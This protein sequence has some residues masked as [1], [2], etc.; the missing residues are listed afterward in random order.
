MM[1]EAWGK[2][3]GRP[4]IVMATRGPGATNA[5]AGLHVARQDST[6]MI[7]LLGQVGRKMRGREA[8]QE[9]DAKLFFGE[10]AKS[11]EEIASA[12]RIP[13][14]F[15]RAMHTATSGRPGPVV[16]SLPEDML[17]ETATCPDA[18]P[19]SGVET[20]PGPAHIARASW[21][22]SPARGG[23]SSSLAGR[24]G[25]RSRL[26][27][28]SA[29][30]KS[31]ICRSAARF[32][33]R[34]SSITI[35]RTMPATSALA[36]TRR[37]RSVSRKRTSSFVVGGRMSEMPSAGYSL[38]EHS[39]PPP[40]AGP[41]PPGRGGARPGLSA[42]ACHPCEPERLRRGARKSQAARRRSAGR[43]KTRAANEAYRT[44]A[45]PNLQSR[46]GAA[47]SAGDLAARAPSR[48]RN[49]D[50]WRRQLYRLGASLL[51]FPPLQ[52]AACADLRID[53]LRPAG[54]DRS[55]ASLPGA[56]G[57]GVRRRRLLPAH[58]PGIGDSGAVRRG[59]ILVIINNGMHGTIRMHQE[60]DYPGRPIATDLVNPDFSALA[61]AHGAHGE[62]VTRTE[63][64]APAFE[65]AVTSGKA[66][67]IEVK[68]DPEAIS[69]SATLSG[70]RGK[71][72]H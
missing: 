61:R 21:N 13:E 23:R 11:V 66:A 16:L 25:A 30:Q 12:D 63:D 43:R 34:C 45:T 59:V 4:G 39:Q 72:R 42:G 47:R 32:A 48:R 8:F 22:F 2:L 7:L 36:S 5:S 33:G 1:A 6:P 46:P 26:R 29:L 31:S 28:R 14:I 54:R 35:I 27:A 55:E 17:R 70:I 64:F 9:I 44:W 67:I 49:R 3:T 65:R 58:Q 53:G 19:W 37:S 60:R 10:V 20:H 71:R 51:P 24:A 50:E 52:Y 56:D 15:S 41:R 69:P 40:E 62:S 18:E 68:I 38:I 57:R